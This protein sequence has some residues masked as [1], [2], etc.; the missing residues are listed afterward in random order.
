MSYILYLVLYTFKGGGELL[1][2]LLIHVSGRLAQQEHLALSM[3]TS[4][5]F[6]RAGSSKA[7]FVDLMLVIGVNDQ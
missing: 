4:R 6:H 7:K 1:L 5:R 3:P 2:L